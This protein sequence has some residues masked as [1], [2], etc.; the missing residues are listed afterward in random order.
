MAM[1][2]GRIPPGSPPGGLPDAWGTPATLAG[3]I[4]LDPALSPSDNLDRLYKRAAR[5]ERSGELAAQRL[6]TSLEELAALEQGQ[7]PSKLQTT[8]GRNSTDKP[9]RKKKGERLPYRSY[10]SPPG[11][12]IRV[13]RG[14]AENDELTFRH[15]KG[16][17]V[18]LHVRGRPGAHVIIRNPGP[19]PSPELLVLADQLALKHSGLKAAAREEVSW[20][21]VKELRKPKGLAPGKVLLRSEK[22]LY[23]TYD[24]EALEVLSNL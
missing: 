4:A 1:T 16:N 14:A 20:T 2:Q 5:A 10:R 17:D 11:L 21:R 22:V 3:G 6:Q 18:W 15:S 8:G 24:P 13:G 9:R 23:L 19:S 7:L 12:E